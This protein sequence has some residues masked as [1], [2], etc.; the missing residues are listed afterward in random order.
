M[1]IFLTIII[2]I[3][4]LCTVIC[5]HELGHLL[6]AKWF[7]VYCEE[8]SIGFGPKLIH[9]NP[10]DKKTKK[11]MWETSI[12]IRC[13]PLGGYVAMV[14]DEEDDDLN[15]QDP[16]RKP[17]PKERTFNAVNHGKQAIIM[18]AGILMNVI[19]SYF[20]F[21]SANFFCKTQDAYTNKVNIYEHYSY[22]YGDNKLENLETAFH[23][24]G[25]QSN[26]EIIDFT[27]NIG[28][29]GLKFVD[30]T[31][32]TLTDEQVNHLKN[33]IGV[34]LNLTNHL[35]GD[36][37]NYSSL[38]ESLTN[39][40][41]KRSSLTGYEYYDRD[42]NKINLSNKNN[43]E[44]IVFY[45]PKDSSATMTISVKYL[46]YESNY[47][48]QKESEHIFQALE[49]TSSNEN[50]A[51]YYFF[52]SMGLKPYMTYSSFKTPSGNKIEGDD[53][54]SW[55]SF[56]DS[57]A[58]SFID[59]GNGVSNVVM[60]IGSLFTP[61]GWQNVGGI[62][63][64]FTTTEQ[65]VELGAYYVLWVWGMISIN[66]AVMNLIPIPG[67]DG[68][69]LM[70]CIIESITKKK[71]SRKF[72]TIASIIGFSIVGILAIALIILDIVRLII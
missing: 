5:I 71:V 59:Q 35:T 14:G 47:Q 46:T 10:K 45:L 2:F 13:I 12:N 66:L 33:D 49:I 40:L 11:P 63:S 31:G 6:T 68:W 57:I 38:S 43:N 44:K 19:L 17:I 61:S 51:A 36:N 32:Y 29:Q 22:T 25:V 65:A 50:S 64:I 55:K 8:F 48:T 60:A 9:I 16:D 62:I 18:I 30:G 41:F 21:F 20:L 69:Q 70:L 53:H 23:T 37:I 42:G 4:G 58:K 39:V 52:P 24:L 34:E 27:I 56:R 3:A 15:N 28:E 26:D 72:K 7:K 54:M 67:L 1:K